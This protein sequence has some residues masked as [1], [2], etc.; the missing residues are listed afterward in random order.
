MTDHA[1]PAP[2][3]V[4]LKATAPAALAAEREVDAAGFPLPLQARAAWGEALG[5]AADRI[6]VARDHAGRAVAALGVQVTPTR[7]LPGHQL[8]RVESLGDAYACPSGRRLLAELARF[9]REAPRLVRTVVEVECRGAEARATLGAWL[10]ELGFLRT[11]PERVSEHTLVIDL[12]PEEDQIL[13]AFSRTTRQ[14][15]R[16][17]AK[18]GAEVTPLTDPVL[19]GRMNALLAEVMVRTGGLATAV[20]WERVMRLCHALPHRSR[21]VGVFRGAGRAP[22]D[23][24]GYVWG[25][26]HGDRV[27]YHTGAAARLPGVRLPVLY[28]ALWDLIT[29]GRRSGGTWFDLGGVTPGTT[30]SSDPLGGISDFKRGFSKEELLLGQEWTLVPS[31]LKGKLAA[32]SSWLATW[33]RRLARPRPT[34][35]PRPPAGHGAEVMVAPPMPPRTAPSPTRL[36]SQPAADE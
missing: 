31:P 8:A 22:G 14:N 26:H 12:G 20:E 3:V 25:L 13:A 15:I 5:S 29:W 1:S 32:W 24:I 18:H 7:A 34:A 33:A 30:G 2:A 10:G 21:L 4:T 23:L 28:P 17:L 11:A 9:T 27:E 16:T 6:L 19:G 36:G 35:P